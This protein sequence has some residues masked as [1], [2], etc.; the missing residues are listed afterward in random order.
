MGDYAEGTTG[1]GPMRKMTLGSFLGKATGS[2][3]STELSV[4]VD[5]DIGG[6]LLPDASAAN[7]GMFDTGCF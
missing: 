1:G 7:G 2:E 3:S 5:S 6:L 4:G